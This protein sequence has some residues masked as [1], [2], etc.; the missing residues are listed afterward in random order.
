M[1]HL[2]REIGGG[3]EKE[4]I[5]QTYGVWPRLFVCSGT[6]IGCESQSASCIDWP[7]F[8]V[9][10][11]ILRL[12]TW[13]GTLGVHW[14]ADDDSRRVGGDAWDR[15]Q[16]TNWW[17]MYLGRGSAPSAI[18]RLELPALV[19][20]TIYHLQSSLRHR[21]PYSRRIWRLTFFGTDVNA[22]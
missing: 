7:Y 9:A 2:H 6:F 20:G 17:Y 21:W 15:Q 12:S 10:V 3:G 18:V 16:H 11:T 8:F 1:K 5:F 13:R 14:V 19:C 4:K 22:F